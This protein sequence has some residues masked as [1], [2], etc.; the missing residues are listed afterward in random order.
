MRQVR[1]QPHMVGWLVTLSFPSH[2][3]LHL[4]GQVASDGE[5]D[6]STDDQSQ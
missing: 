2:W 6:I 1:D 5:S 3:D 4:C